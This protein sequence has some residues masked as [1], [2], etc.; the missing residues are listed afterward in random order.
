MQQDRLGLIVTCMSDAN[1]FRSSLDS[2]TA[3]K[4]V[5]CD[6]GS[7]LQR[8][9]LLASESRDI[10]CL[11]REPNS[12]LARERLN[13][14]RI[15][16]PLSATQPVIQVRDD[17]LARSVRDALSAQCH[18]RPEQAERIS[19]TGHRD[20]DARAWLPQAVAPHGDRDRALDPDQQFAHWLL[21][22]YCLHRVVVTSPLAQRAW[23]V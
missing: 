13:P 18:Q 1:A 22:M 23:Y 21:L 15:L 6:A 2:Y 4:G 17:D 16:A 12:L 20:H 19:A 9:A 7:V 5:A 3:Q 8:A 11:T 14:G 10:N